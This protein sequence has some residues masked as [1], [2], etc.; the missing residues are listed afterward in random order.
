MKKCG[1][2]RLVT[3]CENALGWGAGPFRAMIFVLF[4]QLPRRLV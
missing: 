2:D 3:A 4:H 1:Q